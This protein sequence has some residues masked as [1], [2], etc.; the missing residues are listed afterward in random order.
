MRLT[1]GVVAGI[2]IATLW[3]TLGWHWV[4]WA[5]TRIPPDAP[6]TPRVRTWR[7]GVEITGG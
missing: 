5:L 6:S 7:H 3:H 4:A 1:A 2:T